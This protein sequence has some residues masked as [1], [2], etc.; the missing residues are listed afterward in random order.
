LI[1]AQKNGI[2]EK[3]IRTKSDRFYLASEVYQ[4]SL[5]LL[6]HAPKWISPE[7][8]LDQDV[9]L[10]QQTNRLLFQNGRHKEIVL[11]ST[12]QAFTER[13]AQRF[14]VPR[15][16]FW[17]AWSSDAIPWDGTCFFAS[18]PF[19][20]SGR[21]FLIA[22][23]ATVSFLNDEIGMIRLEVNLRYG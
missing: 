9:E 12:R 8:S 15:P 23:T 17:S 11:F 4:K 6:G 13:F 3:I 19:P 10:A 20:F 22:K 7:D 1:A 5:S 2:S 16:F 14:F 18:P 21:M